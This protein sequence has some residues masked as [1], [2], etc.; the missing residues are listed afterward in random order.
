MRDAIT[1]IVGAQILKW[2]EG[3]L[4]RAA[5]RLVLVIK[6]RALA[7]L[8]HLHLR[9]SIQRPTQKF[10][11]TAR[12]CGADY[13]NQKRG[14]VDFCKRQHRQGRQAQTL[15]GRKAQ[16]GNHTNHAGDAYQRSRY[17]LARTVHFESQYVIRICARGLHPMAEAVT[18][19]R[20]CPPVHFLLVDFLPQYRENGPQFGSDSDVTLD[21]RSPPIGIRMLFS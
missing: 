17:D 15:A 1:P 6:Q 8:L 3:D 5:S 19:L 9:R 7:A 12:Q 16:T 20:N 4:A 18:C 11:G 10:R 13:I 2:I 14:G 21:V